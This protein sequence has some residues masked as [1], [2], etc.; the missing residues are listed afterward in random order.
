MEDAQEVAAGKDSGDGD[1]R[2]VGG[3]PVHR[4]SGYRPRQSPRQVTGTNTSA[5]KEVGP[6]LVG[7]TSVSIWTGDPEVCQGILALRGI[8]A[9]VTASCRFR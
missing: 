1:V 8:A 6:T 4:S 3:L 5:Q 2:A 7:P 9:P